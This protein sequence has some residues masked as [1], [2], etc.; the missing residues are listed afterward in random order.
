MIFSNKKLTSNK[1]N[2][3][4]NGQKINEVSDTK[5]LGVII[6]KKLSWSQHVVI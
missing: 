2:I 5:F 6:D 4:F 1:A 3:Y